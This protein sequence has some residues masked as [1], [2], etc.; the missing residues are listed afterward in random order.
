MVTA[1]AA[2]ADTHRHGRREERG[3]RRGEG[4]TGNGAG[5]QPPTRYQAPTQRGPAPRVVGRGKAVPERGGKGASGR[6]RSLPLEA[7]TLRFSPTLLGSAGSWEEAATLA[8]AM[9]PHAEVVVLQAEVVVP[10]LR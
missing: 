4:G 2:G 6:S 1:Q 9:A 3:E 5:L 8:E 7:A 10:R